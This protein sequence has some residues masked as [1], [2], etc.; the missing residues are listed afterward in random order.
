MATTID[1]K[2]SQSNLQSRLKTRK[3]LGVGALLGDN[4]GDIYRSKVVHR[5]K[6]E[7]TDV[8]LDFTNARH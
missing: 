7:Q 3:L 4:H 2:H 1:G 8:S 5:V 6:T